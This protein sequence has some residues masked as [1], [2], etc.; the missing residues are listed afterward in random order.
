M[1]LTPAFRFAIRDS[2][3]SDEAAA[4]IVHLVDRESSSSLYTL[5]LNKV[6]LRLPSFSLYPFHFT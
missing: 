1:K 3:T 2:W 4:E 6:L 5:S